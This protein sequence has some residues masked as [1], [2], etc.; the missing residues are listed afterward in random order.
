MSEPASLNAKTLWQAGGTVL[1]CSRSRG[2]VPPG[3]TLWVE[4]TT[5][6][7]Q[8]LLRGE[9]KTL[10]SVPRVILLYVMLWM[11]V[12]QSH[13]FKIWQAHAGLIWE[14]N[15]RNQLDHFAVHGWGLQGQSH[16]VL[17]SKRHGAIFPFGIGWVMHMADVGYDRLSWAEIFGRYD[18]FCWWHREHTVNNSISYVESSENTH[19]SINYMLQKR[20]MFHLFCSTFNNSDK[21]PS[22]VMG[23]YVE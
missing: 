1:L 6:G 11:C 9:E 3:P 8:I 10:S 5:C 14:P 18:V 20:V 17:S 15:N 23:R 4:V 12:L 21:G 2:R 16:C 7:G 19:K 22:H 13:L